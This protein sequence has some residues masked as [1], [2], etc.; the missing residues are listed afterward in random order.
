M[1]R[2]VTGFVPVPGHPRS[3]KKYKELGD[4]FS[5]EV[6]PHLE[7]KPVAFM[8]DIEQCWL[9]TYMQWAGQKISFSIG[10]NPAKNTAA[11]HIVQHQKTEWLYLAAACDPSPEE[12]QSYVWIDYGIFSVPGVTGKVI[13]DFLERAKT[14]RG[15]AIPG[16]WQK[17]EVVDDAHPCWRFC[18][19]VFIVPRRYVMPF[20]FACKASKTKHLETTHNLSWEVNTWARVEQ[21]CPWLPLWWYGADHNQTMF[22]HYQGTHNAH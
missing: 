5:E 3:V 6:M 22:S 14:E 4:Q 19:G 15:I 2:V 11:Y 12:I 16:C 20:D 21:E 7:H 8:H 18:G 9:Y 10:D 17:P 13:V 1:L